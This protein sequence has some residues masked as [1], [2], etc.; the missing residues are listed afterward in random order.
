MPSPDILSFVLT[1][2]PSL[3]AVRD[4][5]QQWWNSVDAMWIVRR[6]GVVWRG[7]NDD[8]VN[9]VSTQAF[10]FEAD[11]LSEDALKER[12]KML[13]AEEG[14]NLAKASLV[15]IDPP[16]GLN[17]HSG[18]STGGDWDSLPWSGDDVVTCLKAYEAA[19]FLDSDHIVMIYHQPQ[20][21]GEYWKA[22]EA[23]GYSNFQNMYIYKPGCTRYAQVANASC[24]IYRLARVI[25]W[26]MAAKTIRTYTNSCHCT[27]RMPCTPSKY[28]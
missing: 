18:S 24:Y 1:P 10:L 6:L 13:V 26:L 28:N 9:H 19:G 23:Q 25:V 22:L 20:H 17:K 21:T 3:I 8:K 15:V 7:S 5:L 14:Y 27:P 4:K 16:F 12:H 11:S 2:L